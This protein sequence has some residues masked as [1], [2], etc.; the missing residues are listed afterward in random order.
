MYL[1]SVACMWS[2]ASVG[3]CRGVLVAVYVVSGAPFVAICCRVCCLF[4]IKC[5][6]CCQLLSYFIFAAIRYHVFSPCRICIS[7]KKSWQNMCAKPSPKATSQRIG[8]QTIRNGRRCW[9]LTSPTIFGIQK[10]KGPRRTIGHNVFQE[11]SVHKEYK[12]SLRKEGTKKR[13]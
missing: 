3:I 12:S 6:V 10:K 4:R 9:H 13:L 8:T 1:H 2:K 11:N 7:G 5:S